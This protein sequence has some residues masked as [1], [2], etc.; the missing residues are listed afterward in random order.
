MQDPKRPQDEPNEGNHEQDLKRDAEAT[1]QTREQSDWQQQYDAHRAASRDEDSALASEQFQHNQVQEEETREFTFGKNF[2]ETDE[3]QD[4]QDGS[5][6]DPNSLPHRGWGLAHAESE[7]ARFDEKNAQESETA[8]ARDAEWAKQGQAEKA[9]LDHLREGTSDV[10]HEKEAWDQRTQELQGQ[11]QQE[12][13]QSDRERIQATPEEL[14]KEQDRL[15]AHFAELK[16]EQVNEQNPQAQ[17]EA[18]IESPETQVQADDIKKEHEALEAQQAQQQTQS[19]TFTDSEHR[20][21]TNS[22]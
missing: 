21:Q 3:D 13:K 10:P 16:G 12:D 14:S 4:K 19:D 8:Q 17:I 15:G 2:D 18:A 22:M 1:G 11:L 6:Q 9:Y 20:R 5:A 7:Q